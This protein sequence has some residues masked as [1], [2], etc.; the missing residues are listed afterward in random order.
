MITLY[1]FAPALGVRNPSPLCLKL[2]TY[3]RMADLPYQIAANADLL[4]APKR[5]FSYIT[6][7]G[8]TIADSGFIIKYLKETYGDPL[9]ARLT[10]KQTGAAL[11]MRR[12]MEEHLYWVA[13]YFRW[14]DEKNWKVIKDTFF[15]DLPFPLR[16]IAPSVARS[17][18]MRD[19]Y[20]QGIG[21][22]SRNEVLDLGCENIRAISDFLSDQPYLLGN[23]PTSLDA[24]GYG[25]LI[26]I[27]GASLDSP[28]KSYTLGFNNLVEYCDRMHARYW[29]DA[30][31]E[32][33]T[34]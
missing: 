29:S 10:P 26:N 20:G 27:I 14:V 33:V 34:V 32:P 2:E 8:R 1:Q 12:L 22:H 17:K 4:K 18:A 24:T 16:L 25:T 7:K 31:P 21:R 3:L 11:G 13:F 5:K 28:L 30:I 15:T 6:D 19:L 9:D 23:E